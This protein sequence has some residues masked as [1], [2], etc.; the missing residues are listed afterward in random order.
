MVTDQ[1]GVARPSDLPGVSNAS[2]GSD[3]G[4]VE[5]GYTFTNLAANAGKIFIDGPVPEF[6]AGSQAWLYAVPVDGWTFWG[7]SAAASG[8]NN[9]VRVLMDGDKTVTA[10]FV[11]TVPDTIVD[12][13]DAGVTLSGS[14]IHAPWSISLRCLFASHEYTAT[15]GGDETATFPVIVPR[16]GNYE[17]LTYYPSSSDNANQ[18]YYNLVVGGSV[19]F[20]YAVDQS[21][22]PW[23]RIGGWPIPLSPAQ[24]ISVVIQNHM[25]QASHY[26]RADAVKFSWSTNQTLTP[27]I[28]SIAASGS[29][30][31]TVTWF[32]E[33]GVSYRLQMKTNLTDAVWKD[34][35]GDVTATG[36][37]ASKTDTPAGKSRFYRISR[38]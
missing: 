1:R 17:F 12:N 9:P 4:A 16:S 28:R 10:T 13:Q 33:P 3:V 30:Q 18:A 5:V 38:Q 25:V 36:S 15:D 6:A 37:M 23:R 14:W 8:S 34:V 20:T 11:S 21:Q 7:W 19:L 24:N 27:G 31:F 35:A 2:D 22:S 32:A 29:Q 26:L